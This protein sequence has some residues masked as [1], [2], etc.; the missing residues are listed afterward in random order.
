MKIKVSDIFDQ[1]FMCSDLEMNAQHEKWGN[2]FV[3]LFKKEC[4]KCWNYPCHLEKCVKK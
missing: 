4:P 2:G 1:P 3:E